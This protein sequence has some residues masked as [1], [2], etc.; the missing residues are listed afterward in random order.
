MNTAIST[1][2]TGTG[3]ALLVV[4]VTSLALAGTHHKTAWK[5]S[6]AVTGKHSDAQLSQM[7]K[8]TPTDAAK[9]ALGAIGAP[10]GKKAVSASE[11]EAEHGYLIYSV[12]VKIAGKSGIDEV[13]VDAGDGKVLHVEHEGPSAEA[14]EAVTEKR[15][16]KNATGS[17]MGAKSHKDDEKG[18]EKD[19][20]EKD[21]TEKAEK[22]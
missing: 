19:G 21:G 17:K 9:I 16:G 2:K 4:G 3:L 5:G 10:A 20:D 8:I 15:E 6:I 18:E 11:V 22:K 7:A 14:K 12:E 13:T 1:R